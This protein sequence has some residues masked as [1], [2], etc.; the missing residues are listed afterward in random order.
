MCGKKVSGTVN[1]ELLRR[2]RRTN[3]G[4]LRTKKECSAQ[5]VPDTY[6]PLD[7]KLDL[8]GLSGTFF[9]SACKAFRENSGKQL[10]GPASPRRQPP[11]TISV[12]TDSMP[13]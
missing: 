7:P 9:V 4:V 11:V 10:P 2:V 12:N 1:E 3:K 5:K 6:F 13:R 8:S